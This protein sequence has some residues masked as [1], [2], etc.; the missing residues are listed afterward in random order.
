MLD[1]ILKSTRE[2]ALER[3]A[4][5]ILGSFSVAWCLW[6]Y[7]F[8]VILF[9]S[10]TVSTTFSLIETVAF[11]NTWTLFCRGLL[12]PA[13]TTAVYIFV[14]PYPA[15]FVYGFVRR[16]QREINELRQLIENETPLT[17][18]ESRR[19]RAEVQV[20]EARY[21][22]Q[23]DQAGNEIARLKAEVQVATKPGPATP[24][25]ASPDTHAIT[26]SQLALLLLLEQRGGQMSHEGFVRHNK[27]PKV[28]TEFDLGELEKAGLLHKNYDQGEEDYTYTFTHEGRRVVVESS[29]PPA[30]SGDGR[31]DA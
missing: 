11:P 25:P 29:S 14:Y 8:L 10:A 7:K 22:E 28:K 23:L 6:N 17:L 2:I 5:P 31:G 19:I 15:R 1:D 24:T 30:A 3:L 21:R 26:Q 20:L 18:E 9:S 4:S 16:R 13:L 27:A 12:L